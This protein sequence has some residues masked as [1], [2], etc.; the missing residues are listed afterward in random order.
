MTPAVAEP[1]RAKAVQPS[2]RALTA[3]PHLAEQGFLVG[4][5]RRR[6]DA[7]LVEYGVE[8]WIKGSG[9]GVAAVR[10]GRPVLFSIT[11][12]FADEIAG[13][14]AVL[15]THRRRCRRRR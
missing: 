12:V 2:G 8:R 10:R 5:G 4:V 3:S 13:L 1:V 6:P 15:V 14:L 11:E 7:H 9:A